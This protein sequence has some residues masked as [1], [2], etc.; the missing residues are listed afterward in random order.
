[1]PEMGRTHL[2]GPDEMAALKRR[3]LER[4]GDMYFDVMNTLEDEHASVV[5]YLAH[6][7]RRPDPERVVEWIEWA[8]DDRIA[9]SRVYHF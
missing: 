9:T 8:P 6:S 2:E 4:I 7:D 3:A 5:E 1:M